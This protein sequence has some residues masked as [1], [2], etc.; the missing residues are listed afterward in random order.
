M[1]ARDVEARIIAKYGA[2]DMNL[3]ESLTSDTVVKPYFD[4]EKYHDSQPADHVVS[5]VYT[6][7]INT[8]RELFCLEDSFPIAACSRSGPV[9]GGRYKVSYH[10]IIQGFSLKASRLFTKRRI[11]TP[12][13]T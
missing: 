7:C 4:F 12:L 8:L 10:F 11:L 9:K 6:N 13:A 1:S 3:C 5:C 2:R